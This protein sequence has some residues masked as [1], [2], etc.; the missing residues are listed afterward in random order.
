MIYL[1]KYPHAEIFVG[2]CTPIT[3]NPNLI[4]TL[5]KIYGI[6]GLTTPK[7]DLKSVLEK[8]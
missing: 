1:S 8:K 3:L 7:K 5:T 6:N 2:K 4:L